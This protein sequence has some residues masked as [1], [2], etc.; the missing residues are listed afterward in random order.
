MPEVPYGSAIVPI[1]F[2]ASLRARFRMRIASSAKSQ[3][4]IR[5]FAVYEE[6]SAI[7]TDGHNPQAS[8]Q[9][10][11]TY[12][13]MLTPK[14]YPRTVRLDLR[15]EDAVRRRAN[16][17]LKAAYRENL[18]RRMLDGLI[19]LYATVH[20]TPCAATTAKRA[21]VP[22]P[23]RVLL[24]LDPRI[25]LQRFEFHSSMSSDF[26]LTWTCENDGEGWL[27]LRRNRR[28]SHRVGLPRS[29]V[30]LDTRLIHDS[31]RKGC[32][33]ERTKARGGFGG[34]RP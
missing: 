4:S 34:G 26:L 13:G 32:R 11:R 16:P 15:P 29:R 17:V 33:D 6:S 24:S 10:Y 28:D 5:V 23:T 22:T 12:S 8:F 1:I 21:R 3:G 7:A 20:P 19:A 2:H 25:F 18:F 27:T 31:W 9:L 30:L 14:K